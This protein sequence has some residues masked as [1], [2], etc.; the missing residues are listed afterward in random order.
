MP[1][2]R[3]E[4]DDFSDFSEVPKCS[5]TAEGEISIIGYDVD[6]SAD[7]QQY[8]FKPRDQFMLVEPK[9]FSHRIARFR[10]QWRP[11]KAL[12][13]FVSAKPVRNKELETTG[14]NPPFSYSFTR[15][16]IFLGI[17]SL[18][19]YVAPGFLQSGRQD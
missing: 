19:P 16:P 7:P 3:L 5:R 11:E 4:C 1:L 15:P 10:R 12:A 6:Y 18:G 17:L 2:L 13:E 9:H 14:S 8:L